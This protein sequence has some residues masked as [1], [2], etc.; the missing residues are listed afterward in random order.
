[1]KVSFSAAFK[2]RICLGSVA[3]KSVQNLSEQ[4]FSCDFFFFFRLLELQLN[5]VCARVLFKGFV[6]CLLLVS[7][8]QIVRMKRALPTG[9]VAQASKL[10]EKFHA[11]EEFEDIL[12][13]HNELCNTLQICPGPLSSFYNVIKVGLL[14]LI[15]KDNNEFSSRC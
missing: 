8:W 7:S 9:E 5:S 2:F 15:L 11:A 10:F 13:Y 12:H 6:S 3:K 1:M 14:L 4:S